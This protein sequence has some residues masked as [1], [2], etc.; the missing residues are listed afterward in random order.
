MLRAF[1]ITLVIAL[2]STQVAFGTDQKAQ[3]PS[4]ITV[5]FLVTDGSKEPVLDLKPDEITL[6]VG[7]RESRVHSLELIAAGVKET[8]EEPAATRTAAG[9]PPPYGE[10][11]PPR[12]NTSR[13]IL[14]LVDEG[15][16]F[17]LDEI[18]K[19]SVATLLESLDP[20]DRVALAS[21]RP[22][23]VNVNFT[24]NRNAIAQAIDSLILGRGNTALCVGAVLEHV[25]SLAETLP[26]GRATTLALISRGS[27]SAT[28]V[29]STGPALSGAGGCTFRRDQLAPVEEAVAAAQINYHVFHVGN[30]GLS[31]NLDNFAGSTGARSGILSWTDASA[32]ASAVANNSTFYRAVVDAPPPGRTY[33]RTEFRVTRPDVRVQAPKYLAAPKPLAPAG[34]A[35]AL[36]RGEMRRADLPLR[37]TAFASRNAGPQPLKLVVVVE[38]GDTSAPLYST[39]VAVTAADGEIAG[40]WTARRNDL[41]RSPLVTAIPVNEGTYRIRAAATDEKGRGGIAEYEVRAAL[42]G[43]GPVRLSAVALGVSTPDG[44]APRLL[45][46]NEPEATAYLEIYDAPADAQVSVTF[47]LASSL[48][49]AATAS[50]AGNVSGSGAMRMAVGQLPLKP[51]AAGDTLVRA[52]VT[53][54]GAPA[55]MVVRTLRKAGR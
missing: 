53:V 4:T 6:K 33:Q 11:A 41:L 31:P 50:V 30:T 42:A 13:N 3:T 27:G 26:P 37:V 18:V 24:T 48:E 54:N 38:P 19:K 47:E 49:G 45:F 14:L 34:D 36:L 17:G 20:G 44:F 10:T 32:I 21:T 43:T 28:S 15:T 55:G 25:R 52:R 2:A 35:A 12:E 51:V 9:L 5:D 46:T 23:G 16:L 8:P 22:G 40:Q 39:V 7:G 29:L 1:P